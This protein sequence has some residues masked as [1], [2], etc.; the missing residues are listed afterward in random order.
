MSQL[1]HRTIGSGASE[2]SHIEHFLPLYDF[3]NREV[4]AVILVILYN[5]FIYHSGHVLKFLNEVQL[6]LEKWFDAVE[7]LKAHRL[8]PLIIEYFE[9]SN[10]FLC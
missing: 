4:L 1:F 2:F 8:C 6:Q 10:L 3:S 5:A 9:S 7:S